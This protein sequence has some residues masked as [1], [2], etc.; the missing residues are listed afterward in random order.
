[1]GMTLDIKRLRKRVQLT[2]CGDLVGGWAPDD[3]PPHHYVVDSYAQKAANGDA[4]RRILVDYGFEKRS[5]KQSN[6]QF[7]YW[8]RFPI[9]ET[10]KFDEAIR[11]I[12]GADLP[13]N[14]RSD[15]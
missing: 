1:M 5:Q 12:T 14:W 4:L 2:H 8:W 9:G 7:R 3:N 6:G 11:E 10:S 15:T 13:Q